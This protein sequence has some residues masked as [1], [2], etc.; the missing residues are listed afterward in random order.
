VERTFRFASVVLLEAC[1]PEK[2]FRAMRDLLFARAGII[3]AFAASL[4]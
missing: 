3:F 1:H 4:Y 2:P